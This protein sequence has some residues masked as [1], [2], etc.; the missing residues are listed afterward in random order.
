MGLLDVVL[1]GLVL[2]GMYGL[3]A[4]G[5]NLQYGVARI[6]NLAYGELLMGAAFAAFFLVTVASVDPM[7][8]LLLIVPVAF[9]ASWLL[10]R[11]LMV[12]LVRRARSREQLEAETILST[13]GLLYLL[14][15][16]AM[17]SFGGNLRSYSYLNFPVH[18]LD[19]TFPANRL[20]AFAAAGLIAL[21]LG[22]LLGRTRTG[23]AMRAMAIDPLAAR[24]MGVET[25]R[26]AA[27]AFAAGGALVAAAGTLVS[28]FL[29]FDP[30]V[31]VEFTMKAL[32]VMMMGGVGNMMGSLLAGLLLGVAEALC[33]RFVDGGL[34]LAVAFALFL[35]VLLFRPRGLFRAG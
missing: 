14:K 33:S 32:V 5:F 2:G 30:T 21:A 19:T 3:V 34:T 29:S 4:L 9:G 10:F 20:L 18:F 35:L 1:G 11:Y 15:G 13:F 16:G 24:L 27:L 28:T 12:P 26:L 23:T 6:M 17:V 8:G 25:E 22:L 31:G 7:L